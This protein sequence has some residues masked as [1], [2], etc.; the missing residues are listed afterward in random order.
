MQFAD[1]GLGF[2]FLAGI[3]SFLSPCVFSLVP[4]YVGYLSGRSVASARDGKAHPWI[5]FSHGIF[6][7]LGF[8]T[9]FISLGF[10]SSVLGGL[11]QNARDWLAHIGGLVVIIFGLHMTGIIRLRF[12]EYD[13]RPQTIPHRNRG[14]L[15]SYLMGIFFSAGWSPCVGPVLGSILTLALNNGS[16]SQGTLLLAAYSAGLAIPFLIASAQIGLVTVV[17]KRYGKMM[18]YVEVV[19]GILLVIVGILLLTDRLQAIASSM[20]PLFSSS[21]FSQINEVLLGRWLLIAFVVLALLGLAPGIIAHRKGYSFWTWWIFGATFFI[22]ALPLSI[23]L[24]LAAPVPAEIPAPIA[25]E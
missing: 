15:A 2:S 13:L 9:I 19:M 7:V 22:F 3:A 14:Y 1:I 24:E 11:F 4:A 8:S 16:I 18:H 5:S 20:A 25:P 10:A 23:L 21:F 6:F 17:L 12:L